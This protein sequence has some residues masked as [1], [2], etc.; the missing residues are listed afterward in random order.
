MANED[1]V[2]DPNSKVLPCNNIWDTEVIGSVKGHKV[3]KE[4]LFEF[5][6]VDSLLLHR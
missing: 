6:Y 1:S 2:T 3:L 4:K 5:I